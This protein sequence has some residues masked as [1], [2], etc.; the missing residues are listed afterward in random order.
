MTSEIINIIDYSNLP[1]GNLIVI[2]A[3]KQKQYL[4]QC[5]NDFGINSTQLQILYEI[6]HQDN[7]NQEKIAIRCNIN[8]GA[9]ARSIKKLEDEELVIREID[10]DNRRQNKLSLTKK[11]QK[12]LDTC[13]NILKNLEDELIEGISINKSELQNI[14]KKITINMIKLNEMGVKNE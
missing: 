8:K 14:L 1:I 9:V 11:G 7:S 12:T 10:T 4:N 6:S 5:L 3:K 13:T 2:I